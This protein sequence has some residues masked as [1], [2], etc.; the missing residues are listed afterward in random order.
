LPQA[1]ALAV[2]RVAQEALSNVAKHAGARRADVRIESDAHDLTLIVA[3]DGK[4]MPRRR[5]RAANAPTAGFGVPGMMARCEAFGGS[6]RVLA[7][8]T[9]ARADAAIAQS[10]A[11]ESTAVKGTADSGT[12]VRA[13]F[14]WDALL[15]DA[16]VA[17]PAAATAPG[18]AVTVAPAT[19]AASAL[20]TR[21][22][23]EVANP[24]SP[25]SRSTSA[26]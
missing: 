14:A 15:G 17:Q 11:L 18:S 26:R 22:S 21:A 12:I 16:V 20:L 24:A 3:D 6:L 25:P 7:R 1:A 10:V 4:G 19:E 8:G 5:R 13:R 23:P 2:F 9:R